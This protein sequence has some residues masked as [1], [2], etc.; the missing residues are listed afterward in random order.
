MLRIR[1]DDILVPSHAW[2]PFVRFRQV[3]EWI[4]PHKGKVLHVP[5]ILMSEIQDFPDCIQYIRENV[6]NGTME[7]QVHG[8]KHIDYS[9]LALPKEKLPSHGAID[10]AI[11]SD[12]EI[13]H[14]YQTVQTHLAT[15][16]GWIL[17]QFGYEPHTW[18]TPWG[19]D[20]FVL[21]EAATSVGLK[22][23][24]VTRKDFLHRVYQELQEGKVTVDQVKDRELLMHWWDPNVPVESM[25]RE[26]AA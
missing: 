23:V 7:P 21:R 2:D 1:D 9:R 15:A 25:C 20:N 10:L 18:Y 13:N 12:E 19:A 24:G 5:A 14:H 4:L 3:H 11:F 22:L 17:E 16:K 26:V 6:A 8:L